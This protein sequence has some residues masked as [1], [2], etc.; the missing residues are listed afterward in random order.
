MI[1]GWTPE[2]VVDWGAGVGS[3]AWAVEEVWPA[4]VAE[5]KEQE[6]RE[7]V[8]LEGSRAMVELGS[9]MLGALPAR[10]TKVEGG[11][12]RFEGTPSLPSRLLHLTLPASSSTLAKLH[13]AP[14]SSLSTRTLAL[15]SFS[16][17][18]LPSKEKRRDWIRGMWD[19]GAEVMVIVE[20]G[21]PAGARLVKEAREQLL[22]LGRRNK[23]WESELE[24]V[25]QGRGAEKGCWVMAPVS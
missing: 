10:I 24:E 22:M 2:R 6:T 25:E 13:L 17:A 4:V 5:G 19:S 20:R 3:A 8:G 15:S 12:G 14:S 21:T 18:D 11:D 7:Y 9:R 16:L 23:S 1:D